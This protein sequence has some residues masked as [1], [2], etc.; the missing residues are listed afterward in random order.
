MPPPLCCAR[1]DDGV[2]QKTIKAHSDTVDT[3]ASVGGQ[4]CA[5][6]GRREDTFDLLGECVCVCGGVGRGGRG[7]GYTCCGWACMCVWLCVGGVGV[8]CV[9][10]GIRVC[11]CACARVCVFN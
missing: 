2:H 5:C 10:G 11:V 1:I 3:L 7:G 8:V 4:V 9:G 6:G